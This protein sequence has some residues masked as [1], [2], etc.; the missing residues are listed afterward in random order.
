MFKG[1]VLAWEHGQLVHIAFN[2]FL[3]TYMASSMANDF[4][5]GAGDVMRIATEAAVAVP[6]MS[7]YTPLR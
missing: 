6:G 3:R 1:P 4:Y 7:T 2:D 5:D